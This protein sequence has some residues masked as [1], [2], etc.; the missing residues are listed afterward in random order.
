MNNLDYNNLDP[1]VIR[2]GK[3]L[4]I[5]ESSNGANLI[6]PETIAN[7]TSGVFQYKKETFDGQAKALNGK[8]LNGQPLDIN[9]PEDQNLVWYT[10]AK[11]LKDK[12]Y[13]VDQISAAHN[14]GEGHLT[15][16]K[17]LKGVSKSGY[18][19]DTP[20][21]V[22]D[23]VAKYQNLKN[24]DNLGYNPKPYSDPS[25]TG[26]SVDYTKIHNVNETPAVDE[27]GKPIDPTLGEELTKR[28]NDLTLGINSIITGKKGGTGDSRV[29]GLIQ[30]AGALAG[31][32]G[33]VISKGLEL[34][35]GVKWLED[36]IGEGVGAL[37]K[38]ET[39]QSVLKYMTEQAKTH[40]ELARDIGA[41]FN[42]ITAIPILKGLSVVGKVGL[43]ASSQALKNVAEKSFLKGASEIISS[44]KGGASFLERNPSV[45]QKMLDKRL[46][47]EIQGG[48]YTTEKAIA[49]SEKVISE[50]NNKVKN[51]LS[52]SKNASVAQD[53]N[54]IANKAITGYTDRFG[55]VVE[56]LPNAE[57]SPSQ[58]IQNGRSLTP[59][60]KALW[61]KFEAGQANW[62][63]INQLRS[64]LDQAVSKVFEGGNITNP[65]KKD[66]G[67]KLSSA[68]RDE[69]QIAVPETQPLFQ[70]MTD[71]FRINKA[72]ELMDGKAI[73][74]GTISNMVGHGVGM[75]VGAGTGAMVAGPYGAAVGGFIGDRTGNVIAKKVA[76]QNI[77]Q[78]ILKRSGANAIKTPTKKFITKGVGNL[79][80]GSTLQ[81][82]NR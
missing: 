54:A 40:P 68:M 55:N 74:P 81:K 26:E 32:L 77:T 34:I 56:G 44:T 20:K 27:E 47:G 42:I 76:G 10:W 39:G 37:A 14:A 8:N 70:E 75:G 53:G 79:V 9:N 61:N 1:D 30:T 48:K 36:Q 73:K 51:I 41:G 49:Q 46:I 62:K 28:G 25:G 67:A 31:G 52:S 58:L 24:N 57:L 11:N 13:G 69:L 38:T 15:D 82:I 5:K 6:S 80:T 78:G 3:A 60:N 7:G 50:A 35:P 12:G 45:V 16:W 18:A 21:Y 4:K 17:D 66:A 72:L 2:L 59:G 65:F 43:E 19:Y 64:D 23:A 29:S 71:H 22:E 33:D 63:E